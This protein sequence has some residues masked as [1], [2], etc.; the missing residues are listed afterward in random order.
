MEVKKQKSVTLKKL[1]E[2]DCMEEEKDRMLDEEETELKVK[3]TW[4][5]LTGV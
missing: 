5:R 4:Y 2:W 3:E 1:K